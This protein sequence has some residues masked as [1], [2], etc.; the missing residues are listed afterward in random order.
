[1]TCATHEFRGAV[2]IETGASIYLG[3]ALIAPPKSDSQAFSAMSL[4]LLDPV[5]DTFAHRECLLFFC[6]SQAAHSSDQEIDFLD[7]CSFSFLGA[8]TGENKLPS[9]RAR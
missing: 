7:D 2:H 8:G 3:D 4:V 5:C 1:M 9:E 6:C